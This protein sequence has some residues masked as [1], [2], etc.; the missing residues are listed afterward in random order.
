MK[1]QEL[2]LVAHE[3]LPGL[4]FYVTRLKY[5]ELH[6]HI[7]AE[8][9]LVLDGSGKIHTMQKDTPIKKGDFFYFNSLEAHEVTAVSD[10]ML[11]F[12]IQYSPAILNICDTELM[13]L[14]VTEMI[15]TKCLKKA[16]IY[17][18]LSDLMIEAG[19]TYFK[20]ENLF[21]LHCMSLINE[22][23]YLFLNCVPVIDS[24]SY[25]NQSY[26]LRM[27]RLKRLLTYIDEHYMER[28]T[29]KELAKTEHLSVSRLSHFFQ[30]MLQ[31][32]F[33][34]YLS[35]KR[36]SRACELLA[37]PACTVTRAAEES[38]FS[39]TRYLNQMMYRHLNMSAMEYHYFHKGNLGALHYSGRQDYLCTAE[40]ARE[41]LEQYSAGKSDF[42]HC[43]E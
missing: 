26:K 22:M 12:G 25:D 9:C 15:P 3:I 35:Q 8:F 36:F 42:L 39:S 4:R 40:Q 30:E 19:I 1:K 38:G 28:L 29:I 41:I 34:T 27:N 43:L 21:A 18:Y 33:Q 20:K 16:G 7:D 2:E 5:C 24:R 31:M 17:E 11:I 13:R 6:L 32:S 37:D 23:L 10:K 14:R